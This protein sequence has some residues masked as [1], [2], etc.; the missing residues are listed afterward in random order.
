MGVGGLLSLSE[1]LECDLQYTQRPD[2]FLYVHLPTKPLISE[3]I[4][5]W[6]P[7]LVSFSLTSGLITAMISFICLPI[8]FCGI[9]SDILLRNSDKKNLSESKT[10]IKIRMTTN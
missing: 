9:T 6:I 3:I 7:I 10:K 8:V 1:F 2:K 5:P 4:K